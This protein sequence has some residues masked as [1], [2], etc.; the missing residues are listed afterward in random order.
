MKKIIFSGI[1]SL[2]VIV[3]LL[4]TGCHSSNAT[5][6]KLTQTEAESIA[7]NF[8]QCGMASLSNVNSSSPVRS[9]RISQGI[10]KTKTLIYINCDNTMPCPAGGNIH[11]LGSV[12]GSIDDKTGSGM[13]LIQMTETILDCR[14]PEGF[15]FNGDPY[16]SLAG[17]FSFLNWAPA[18]QQTFSMG[19][20]F[21]WT[22]SG[23]SSIGSC[24]IQLTCNF[25]TA[26]SPGGSISGSICG[27]QIY[28][29]F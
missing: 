28:I 12:S 20:G 15:V 25:E 5:S 26:A 13:L 22:K 9:A 7:L 4:L 10:K 17:V 2:L 21:K 1:L 6:D 8:A 29:T 3:F 16:I 23:T 11:V 24:Q 27:R 14:Y 19:G 18:T